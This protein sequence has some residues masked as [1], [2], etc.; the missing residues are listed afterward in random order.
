MQI[1]DGSNIRSLANYSGSDP[2]PNQNQSRIR[3]MDP[4][5]KYCNN[6]LAVYVRES[7]SYER[8]GRA[9][10]VLILTFDAYN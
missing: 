6:S 4:Q 8:Q 5:E 7:R 2:D 3:N 1:P 9:I 10:A